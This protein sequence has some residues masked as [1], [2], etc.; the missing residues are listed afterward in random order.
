MKKTN[1]PEEIARVPAPSTQLRLILVR[2]GESKANVAGV[3]Q[4]QSEGELTAKGF[5]QADQVG[6]HLQA[7]HIDRMLVS[8][9]RRARETAAHISRHLAIPVE[10]TAQ[11]REW[12]AGILDG[13]PAAA[14]PAAVQASGKPFYEFK[15]QGGERLL[16]VFERAKKL[17]ENLGN[18]KRRET[19]L[20]VSHGDFL[21]M[22]LAVIQEISLEEANRIHLDNTSYSI[23]ERDLHGK[24]I[25]LAVNNSDHL[26]AN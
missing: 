22:V 8:D 1:T 9:L 7:F 26:R 20:V 21:R 15:P 11:V 23:A 19:V 18:E 4:G 10:Y 5:Q 2:H 14:L 12:D 6:A 17:I 13:Q 25:I 24:W 3:L 16:D